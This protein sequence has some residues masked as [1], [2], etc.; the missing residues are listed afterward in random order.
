M[1]QQ[2]YRRKPWIIKDNK[3][4]AN[5]PHSTAI[6][7]KSIHREVNNNQDHKGKGVAD[8]SFLPKL[9]NPKFASNVASTE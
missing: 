8:T 2:L 1:W 9:P 3:R 5:K 7:F 4:E 6:E